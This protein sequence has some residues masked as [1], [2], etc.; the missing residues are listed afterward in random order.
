MK[1]NN[2]PKQTPEWEHACVQ[3]RRNVGKRKTRLS[4]FDLNNKQK[5]LDLG[6]GDGLNI[7]VLRKMG[8]K[9]IVGVDI[10]QDLINKAKILNPKNKFYKTSADKLPFKNNTFDIVLVDSVFH[11]L[12]SYPKP[13]SEIDRVLINGG[14]LCFIEPHGS[15]VRSLYDRICEMPFASYIPFLRE[16]SISYLGEIKFMKHWIKTENDFYNELIKQGFRKV[17]TKKDLLSIIGIYETS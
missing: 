2:L 1:K 6:C 12:M 17:L 13:V 3:T 10:S 8:I 15:W 4:F 7:K 14:K 16:R 5:I 9:N 11:H